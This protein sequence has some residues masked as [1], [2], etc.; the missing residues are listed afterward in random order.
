M[1]GLQTTQIQCPYCWEQFETVVDCSVPEQT[2]IEDCYVC[3]Q[4]IV[5]HV[6][7]EDGATISVNVSAEH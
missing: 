6:L 1:S 2:Y 7:V 3:C 5:L 4:P